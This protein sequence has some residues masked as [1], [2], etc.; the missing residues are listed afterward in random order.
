MARAIMRPR[1]IDLV[2]TI[3]GEKRE[4]RGYSAGFANSGRYGGGL[5]LSP[6]ASVDDGLIDVRPGALKVR[7][8]AAR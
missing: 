1:R 8:P 6:S 3:D 2:L 4:F 5:K 7:V